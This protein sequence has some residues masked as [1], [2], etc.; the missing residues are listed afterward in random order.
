[1]IIFPFTVSSKQPKKPPRPSLPSKSKVPQTSPKQLCSDK[2]NTVSIQTC[3][4]DKNC[5]NTSTATDPA[6]IQHPV[7][8]PRA[9]T[10]QSSTNQVNVPPL[11]PLKDSWEVDPVT[12]LES[13]DGHSGKYLKEL[14]DVFNSEPQYDLS[15]PVNIQEK[16]TDLSAQNPSENMTALHSDRN[17]RAKIQAFESQSNTESDETAA[18]LP[19]PRKAYTKPPVLAPKPS[20]APRPSVR[21]PKE[22]ELPLANHVH[23]DVNVPPTPAPRPQSFKKPSSSELTDES[24]FQPPLRMIPIPPSRPSLVRAKNVS[25]QDDELVFKGLPSP[26]KP[27]RDLLNFNNHNST[28]LL[29]NITSTD[30]VQTN[31]FV[32]AVISKC[33]C[34]SGHNAMHM[35]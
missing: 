4:S 15:N 6:P 31:D 16:K 35:E 33:Q 14:L 21:K 26:L 19:R 22:E 13:S 7:P 17:I 34:F 9:K 30:N 32:D 2:E 8:R 27:S 24:D 10:K 20:I 29:P 3:A 12:P 18:P 25:S 23:E 11:I 5:S 28:A 1:M